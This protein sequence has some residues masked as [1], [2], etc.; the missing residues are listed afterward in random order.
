MSPIC[1]RRRL[2]IRTSAQSD[3]RVMRVRC[4]AVI[5]PL[6]TGMRPRRSRGARMGGVN[7]RKVCDQVIFDST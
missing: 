3:A 7:V 5:S 1:G 4:V 6:L 2:G